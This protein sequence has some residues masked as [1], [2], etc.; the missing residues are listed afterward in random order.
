MEEFTNLELEEGLS[1][2][3]ELDGHYFNIDSTEDFGGK[4][5][6]P[7]PKSLMLVALGGCTGMDVASIMKKMK[8]PFE[9]MR[10]SVMGSL[11]EEHPKHYYKMHITFRI[12]GS[13]INRDKV[14]KAVSLSQERY[15]GVMF[16]YR[17]SMEITHEIIIEE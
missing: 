1:F 4:N 6:G 16:S 13:D 10:V 9:G 15:C 12:K 11:T 17:K 8:I 7:R 3:V 2:N 5:R 14:E